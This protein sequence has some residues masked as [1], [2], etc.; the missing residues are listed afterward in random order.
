MHCNCIKLHQFACMHACMQLHCCD[1]LRVPV[2]AM[3]VIAAVGCRPACCCQQCRHH[4]H[5]H[6]P[7]T[8]VKVAPALDLH[9]CLPLP[10]P[11]ALQQPSSNNV[12]RQ[13]RQEIETN[14]QAAGTHRRQGKRG[15]WN[16]KQA[17]GQPAPLPSAHCPCAAPYCGCTYGAWL[18]APSTPPSPF[19]PPRH[20]ISATPT[21]CSVEQPRPG[22]LQ[23]LQPS[24]AAPSP[25]PLTAWPAPARP[26]TA[27]GRPWPRPPGR[28]RA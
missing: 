22:A 13:S 6:G 26:P 2:C 23:S 20:H 19:H 12:V 16:L 10:Y 11:I 9:A 4:A 24:R 18:A 28:R 15:T 1:P 27:C 5:V 25:W 8:P 17:S 14:L 7:C 21:S 3:C